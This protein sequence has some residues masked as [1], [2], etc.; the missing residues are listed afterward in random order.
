MP[1]LLALLL[2]ATPA[3]LPLRQLYR[4]PRPDAGISSPR[5]LDVDGDGTLDLVFGHGLEAGPGRISAVSGR[6]GRALW[7]T[8]TRAEVY[9]TALL[10]DAAGDATPELFFGGRF[11]DFAS[12]DA[13]TGKRRW[14]LSETAGAKLPRTYFN[15]AVACPDL[16]GDGR[17]DLLVL[18]SGTM[19]D[20]DR[21]PA[22]IRTISSATGKILSEVL[23]FDGRESYAVPLLIVR[24]DG[25]LDAVIGTGGETLPGHLA[26]IDLQTGAPRWRIATETKGVV[27]APLGLRAADGTLD[28]VAASVD[29]VVVRVDAET[30]AV[31]WRV[32]LPGTEVY[33]SVSPG[34]FGGDPAGPD[35]VLQH[36]RGVAPRWNRNAVLWLHGAT[37]AKLHEASLGIGAQSSPVVADLDGDGRDETIV[38]ADLTSTA[39]ATQDR[40]A[41]VIYDGASFLPRFTAK[42]SGGS[43]VTPLLQDLDGD[44][45]LDL[46]HLTHGVLVRWALPETK[47][48]PRWPGLRGPAFDA[49]HVPA[50]RPAP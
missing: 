24:A 27:A 9:G 26:R 31:R 44:G 47:T 20:V 29:G 37:G 10:L 49:M 35:L 46:I 34:A 28:V 23:S 41:L 1:L 13:R 4:Q 48:P 43:S 7:T 22:R 38:T 45:A 33:G 17:Q 40:S 18:Q 16:D 12:F 19:H 30:G 11:D 8:T 21:E 2:A 32:E 42:L 15:T 6:T 39:S 25:G 14:L 50:T 3:P 5:A 36:A